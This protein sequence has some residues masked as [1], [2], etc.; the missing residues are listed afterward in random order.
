MEIDKALCIPLAVAI[1]VILLS[2]LASRFLKKKERKIANASIEESASSTFENEYEVFLSFRGRDTR[3]SFTDYL[4][5]SLKRDG[6]SVFRD[7]DELPIGEEIGPDLLQAIRNSKISIPILSSD[8]ASSKWCLRELAQ[9][10]ECKRNEGHMVL[11]IFYKVGPGDVRHQTGRFGDAFHSIKKHY[12]VEQ[13]QQ[14]VRALKEVGSLKGWESEKIANG[15]EG[16]LVKIIVKK[17]L[18]E[19]KEDLQLDV[20]ENLVGISDHIEEIMR[21]LSNNDSETRFVGI[22]GMGGVGKTTLAK[23]IFNKLCHQFNHCSFLADVRETS[24][25]W[26]AHHLQNQLISDFLK[27]KHKHVFNVD[28]GLRIIRKRFRHAKVLI[29]LDDVDDVS[30]LNCLAGNR[31]WFGLGSKIII[32]TRKVTVLDEA[33]V[34]NSYE[35]NGLDADNSLL[36][37]S[38]NA[39]RRDFPL[40]EFVD[41]SHNIVSTTGGL[42]LT[43]EVIGSFLCRKSIAVW[44]ETLKKLRKTPRKEVQAKL[45]ISYDALDYEQQQIFLDIACFFVGTDERIAS[46]MRHD[47]EYYPQMGIDELRSMSLIKV[48]N[49]HRL[50]MH[51]QL[52]DLGREIVRQEGYEEPWKRSRLWIH[53][54]SLHALEKNKGTAKIKAL[55]LNESGLG[56]VCSKEPFEKLPSLRFLE[57]NNFILSGDFK[58][59]LSELRWLC[60]KNW[61]SNFMATNFHVEKLVIFDLSRSKVTEHWAGWNQISTAS[62]LK[63]LNISN[64]QDLKTSP[65][66]TDFQHLEILILQRC[67]NQTEVHPS[68]GNIHTLI[69]LDVRDCWRLKK[70]PIEV[71]QLQELEELFI[72]RTRMEEIPISRVQ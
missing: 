5:T 48:G 16:E 18:A 20:T 29:L 54:E 11:P 2:V 42:P 28:E 70:L 62:N 39:F 23:V 72:D 22:H 68:I 37:F 9:M 67:E 27:Q 65:D 13:V 55:R 6:I 38:R 71:N 44:E 25:K 46:Y 69:S 8:Y 4:Y 56:W 59:L 53:K 33:R 14:W 52:R 34:D 35:L 58:C 26:G 66:L 1:A 63:V 51:D 43:L 12:E 60:W 19:L 3:T 61:P 49:D 50:L 24:E 40:P 47:C 17:V 32:T 31:D 41:L 21:M 36:L 10:I 45:K 15:H 64:C 57:M 7:D 30:Q